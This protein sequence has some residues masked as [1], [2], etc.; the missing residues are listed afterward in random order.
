MRRLGGAA[1]PRVV[2]LNEAGGL[3]FE[4][5]SSTGRRFVKWMPA[6]DGPIDLAGEAD[7]LRWASAFIAVPR[8][9]ELGA[10]DDGTWLLTEGL[11]GENAV[12]ERWKMQPAVAVAAIGAGLRTFHDALPVADCPFR[13]QPEEG[14]MPDIPPPPATEEPVVCHGDSCAPNTLIGDD[15]RCSGHVDL[16]AMGVGDRWADLAIATWS[17]VWNYGPGWENLLLDAYG[18]EPDE[19]RTE[20]FR[21]LWGSGPS[22]S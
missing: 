3:T 4:L 12:G 9:L 2:W 18:I 15:G 10:D 20:Y 21:T 11:T 14:W 8:V 1:E 17:T 6:G 22:W 16:G 19:E 13:W 7:R 5:T